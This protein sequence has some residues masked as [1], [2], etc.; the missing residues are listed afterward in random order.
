ML[1]KIRTSHQP[2]SI[3]QSL[4]FDGGHSIITYLKF[5]L[6]LETRAQGIARAENLKRIFGTYMKETFKLSVIM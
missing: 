4:H 1:E 5:G 6:Q 2:T 3:S